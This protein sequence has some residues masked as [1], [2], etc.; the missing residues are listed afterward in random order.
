MFR[1]QPG[2]DKVTLKIHRPGLEGSTSLDASHV[3]EARTIVTGNA[4]HVLIWKLFKIYL[5][6]T[7]TPSWRFHLVVVFSQ[8]GS[9]VW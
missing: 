6:H 5:E 2:P 4:G 8:S 7:C 9:P 1:K 3:W